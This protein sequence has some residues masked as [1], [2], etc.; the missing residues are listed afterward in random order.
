MAQTLSLKVISPPNMEQSK[1]P[2]FAGYVDRKI[3]PLA[4]LKSFVLPELY[5]V[6]I[7]V[8][9][10]LPIETIT[11]IGAFKHLPAVYYFTIEEDNKQAI[12]EAY[13]IAKSS[14]SAINRET[15]QKTKGYKNI[16]HVPTHKE[17]LSGNC[18][19]VGSVKNNLLTRLKQH[20][21]ETTSGRTGALYLK[22]VLADMPQKPIITF[23]Y[24]ILKT[25]HKNLTLDI[26]AVLNKTY[27]PILGKRL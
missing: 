23:N 19:Y 6:T 3:E 18:L 5:R 16:C 13:H 9:G 27:A 2:D 10:T 11:Q 21:G 22:K 8:A 24:H 7:D 4:K 14:S 26:E 1:S 15:G 25:E 20:M 17:P 12:Y